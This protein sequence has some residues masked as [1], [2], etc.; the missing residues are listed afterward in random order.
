MAE[1]APQFDAGETPTHRENGQFAT[2]NKAHG[3]RAGRPNKLTLERIRNAQ[4]TFAP[5]TPMAI[6][7]MRR[8]LKGCDDL[9]SCASCRHYVT[10]VVEYTH[11][12]PVQPTLTDEALAALAAEYGKPVEH[13]RELAQRGLRVVR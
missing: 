5:L 11:G 3:S 4:D 1:T 10:I 13:V 6:R 2:G 9:A 8:H 7:K 12:K